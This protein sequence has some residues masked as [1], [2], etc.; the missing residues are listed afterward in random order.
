MLLTNW[1]WPYRAKETGREAGEICTWVMAAIPNHPVIEM[2]LDSMIIELRKHLWYTQA[3]RDWLTHDKLPNNVATDERY[4]QVSK[5]GSENH[6]LGRDAA[7]WIMGPIHFTRIVMKYGHASELKIC[8]RPTDGGFI[9]D[10]E[11]GHI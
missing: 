9:C 2:T 7:A 5:S 11:G 10:Y 8:P 1:G 3:S 4:I 6:L